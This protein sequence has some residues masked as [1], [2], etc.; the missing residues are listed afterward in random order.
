MTTDELENKIGFQIGFLLFSE[1]STETTIADL[2]KI[3]IEFAE[4]YKNKADKWD[5]LGEKIARCYFDENGDDLSEE[6]SE[7]IDLG[8]IGEKAA[9]AYGWL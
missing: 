9:I 8:T 7:D 5:A 4:Q 2:K 6:E 3:A 1:K